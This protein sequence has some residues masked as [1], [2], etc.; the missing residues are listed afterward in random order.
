MHIG[1]PLLML[2]QYLE[3]RLAGAPAWKR[4]AAG[5]G[6]F[7]ICLAVIAIGFLTAH[8]VLILVGAVLALLMVRQGTAA[9]RRGR[10]RG[11]PG[12]EPGQ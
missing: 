7:A 11:E 1:R 8:Y 9:I 5:I 2:K 6:L 12:S 4:A 10:R 3:L